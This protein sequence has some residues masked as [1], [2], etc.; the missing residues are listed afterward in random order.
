MS[1]L[2]VLDI[3]TLSDVGLV[4]IFSQSVGYPF[5]LLTVSFALQKLRNFMRSH[6]LNFDLT[7]QAIGVLFSKISPVTMYL[8]L[9]HTFSSISFSVSGFMWRSLIYLDLSFV[10]GDK[11]RSICILLYADI[12]LN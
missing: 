7:A 6:L 10:Q 3:S 9:F 4:K 2:Y 5:V 12:C 1:S 8:R 11:N